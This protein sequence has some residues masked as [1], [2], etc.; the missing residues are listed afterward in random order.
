LADKRDALDDLST[1][2]MKITEALFAEH[3]V[4]HNMFDHI[5]AATPKLK[6]LAEVKAIAATMESLLKAHSD[7]ED[8]LFIGPLEL[9]FE[10]IGQREA[11]L[12][13][14]QEIDD[15]LKKL[16]QAKTLKQ[17]RQLLL[18]AVSYS[19]E[20]FGKEER[21][22]FPLAERVLNSKTLAALGQKWMEQRTRG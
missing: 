12:E 15:S 13:E 11:F 22:V 18:A 16:R 10:E 20:H 19:R 21:F 3:L 5:E 2:A 9:C 7:T 1:A 8:K 14:H 6:T 4:F 17:A